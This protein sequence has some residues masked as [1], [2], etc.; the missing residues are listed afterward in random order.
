MANVLIVDDTPDTC[1]ILRRVIATWGHQ[2]HCLFG[3]GDV[4]NTL[5]ATPYDLV[6]LDVMMPDIDGFGVL[7]GIRADAD[8]TLA[9]TPVAMYSAMSDPLQQQRAVLSGANEWIIKGTPFQLL[10]QRL[11][12]FLA[13]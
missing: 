12:R 2:S 10:Q 5:R 9:K 8:P 13:G 4:L 11:E 6:I 3:G 7:E 1:E